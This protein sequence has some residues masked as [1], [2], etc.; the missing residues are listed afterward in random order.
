[1]TD[2]DDFVEDPQYVEA[3]KDRSKAYAN[4]ERYMRRLNLLSG[5]PP[6]AT[7]FMDLRLETKEAIKIL[8]EK[9]DVCLDL[10]A[11]NCVDYTKDVQYNESLDIYDKVVSE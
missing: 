10:I 5:K 4:V 6:N 1:M 8:D 9:Q 11:D 3:L 7:A 2:Y